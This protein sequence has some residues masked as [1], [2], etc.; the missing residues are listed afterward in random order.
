I[1]ISHL[2]TGVSTLLAAMPAGASTT[3]MASKFNRDPQFAVQLVIFTTLCSI[4]AI[5]I[6]SMILS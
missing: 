6:W 4:P 5:M 1:G 2:V 3:M